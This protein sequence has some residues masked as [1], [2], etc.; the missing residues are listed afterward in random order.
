MKSVGLRFGDR[1]FKGEFVVTRHGIEGGAVYALSAALRDA[2]ERDGHAVLELDL[3]PDW[4]VDKL[5]AALGRP[6]GIR[7]VSSPLE[8]QAGIAGGAAGLA[9]E[10]LPAERLLDAAALKALPLRLSAPRPIAEA[11]SS[12]GGLRFDAVDEHFMLKARPGGFAAG[13][14]LDWEAPTGGYLL[15]ACFATGWA[16]GRAAAD[17]LRRQ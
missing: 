3:K 11:I 4:S 14:M 8:R 13:E 16:A 17:W 5:A 9:R 10:G 12:A 15:T 1:R 7:S 2:I 6:R